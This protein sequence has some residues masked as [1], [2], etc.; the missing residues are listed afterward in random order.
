MLDAEVAGFFPP[1]AV[2]FLRAHPQQGH[3]FNLFQWGGYLEWKLPQDPTFIDSRSDIFE[4]KG[5]L[6]DYSDIAG[7]SNSQEILER[8]QVTYLLYP[9]DTALS[10]FLSKCPQWERIY[11]DEQAVIYRNIG[12]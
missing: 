1:R 4:H 3:M 12:R 5:V 7:L 6:K 11:G 9:P 8:Y 10:Y 2:D